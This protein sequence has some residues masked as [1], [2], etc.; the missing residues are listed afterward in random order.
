MQK[1]QNKPELFRTCDE[2]QGTDHKCNEIK[3]EWFDDNMEIIG[4]NEYTKGFLMYLV[5]VS[6]RSR[7]FVLI[8]CNMK[9]IQPVKVRKMDLDL[10]F[11]ARVAHS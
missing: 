4:T 10:I 1:I 2:L 11:R 9:H 3:E 8:I 5:V 7:T 6:R